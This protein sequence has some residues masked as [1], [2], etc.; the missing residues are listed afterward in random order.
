LG[1]GVLDGSTKNYPLVMP[2]N[3]QQWLEVWARVKS[4]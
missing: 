3:L 2:P 1:Y 4:A